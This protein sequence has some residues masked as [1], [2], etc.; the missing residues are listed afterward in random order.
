MDQT[1]TTAPATPPRRRRRIPFIQQMAANECGA[2]CLAMSLGYFGKDVVVEDVTSIVAAGR[3]GA[4]LMHLMHGARWFGLRARGVQL[5]VAELAV[6]GA[7]AILHWEFK[8]FVVFERLRKDGVVVVDPALGRRTVPLEQ[9][10]RSFTGV[11]LLLEPSDTFRPGKR[12][13]RPIWSYLRQTLARSGSWS[14]ILVTSLLLQLF[15]LAL[16]M[17]T[18]M[19]VDRIVPRGDGRLLVVTAVGLGGLVGF[20]FLASMVR[21]HLLLHLRTFLDSRMTLGFIEHLL[22]LRYGFFQQRPTGDL[23][24]RVNSNAIIREMLTSGTLSALIDGTFVLGYLVLLV[25]ASPGIALLALTLAAMQVLVFVL[26]WPRQRALMVDGIRTQ[27][28]SESYLVELLSGI[29]TLKAS[30]TELRAG[31]RWSSLFVDQL[32]VSFARG[33]MTALVDALTNTLRMGAPLVLLCFG[34]SRV[35]DGSLTLGAMLSVLALA[36]GLLT[37]V[38]SLVGSASQLMML[39]GYL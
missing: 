37:P 22:E 19:V 4:N 33:K 6:V 1:S 30:G 32:N 16:P 15:A 27:S 18:G 17:L 26:S 24:N 23:M 14:R 11:A 25:I 8:H 21:S 12:P 29:E 10:R 20:Y 38:S 28:A 31:E 3:D 5:D 36:Q 13:S 39:G 9:F 35:L 2:A 34:A 7:G